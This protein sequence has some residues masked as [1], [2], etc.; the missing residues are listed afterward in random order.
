MILF[1]QNL[2]SVGIPFLRFMPHSLEHEESE[3]AEW[4]GDYHRA[5]HHN[6]TEISDPY[7][8]VYLI[9]DPAKQHGVSRLAVMSQ[10]GEW[11]Q[12]RQHRT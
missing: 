5:Q 6:H 11:Q 2:E 4:N 7:H 12:N 10:R 9:F 1:F 8:G 3:N